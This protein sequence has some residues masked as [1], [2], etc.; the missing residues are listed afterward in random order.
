MNIFQKS[1]KYFFLTIY[2]TFLYYFPQSTSSVIGRISNSLRRN[3]CK[4]IFLFMGDNVTIE[5]KASFGKGFGVRLGNN[6]GIGIKCY[7]PN[8]IRIGNNVMMG[9][10][11]HIFSSNHNFKDV[12]IPMI[13]QGMQAPRKTIIE[14]DVWIGR[15]V[16]FTPGR[17][18][19]QGSI[20]A[21]GTVLC[22]NF[23][24]YSIIGGN[25]SQLIKKR[26]PTT[27]VKTPEEIQ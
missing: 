16:I 19:K 3:C 9:P 15:S 12:N 17:I 27:Q 23:P 2:Y 21:A 26:I 13:Q 10:H 6:S 7:V 5:R 11:V 18:I 20:I 22:K 1:Y 24:S 25:P 4:H 14:D 8:D